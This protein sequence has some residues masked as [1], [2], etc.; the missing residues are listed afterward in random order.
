MRV[1]TWLE[2]NQPTSLSESTCKKWLKDL[3]LPQAKLETLDKN[4][5]KATQWWQNQPNHASKQIQ[6]VSVAMGLQPHKSNRR[7]PLPTSWLFTWWPWLFRSIRVADPGSLG[8]R[9]DRD[10]RVQES[11][12]LPVEGSFLRW[13]NGRCV[14]RNRLE[15]QLNSWWLATLLRHLLN[16]VEIAHSCMLWQFWPSVGKATRLS[17]SWRTM[18]EHPMDNLTLHRHKPPETTIENMIINHES[19]GMIIGCLACTL[20]DIYSKYI[21]LILI[22]I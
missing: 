6:R 18:E 16:T 10:R 3:K 4:F 1:N 21:H 17:P 8:L 15:E 13:V 5:T 14:K 7:I 19:R 20:K 2:N 9:L 11:A 12:F 22:H